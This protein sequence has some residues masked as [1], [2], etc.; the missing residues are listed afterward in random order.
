MAASE[1]PFCRGVGG[2]EMS[3]AA[4][5]GSGGGV[6]VRLGEGLLVMSLRGVVVVM[7]VLLFGLI[8][9]KRNL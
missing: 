3:E 4:G 7:R 5:V 1:E 6:V 2:G 8:V 9:A